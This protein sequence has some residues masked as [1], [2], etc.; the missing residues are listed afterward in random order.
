MQAIDLSYFAQLVNVVGSGAYGRDITTV[1]G[2]EPQLVW[3]TSVLV[4]VTTVLS[5]PVAQAADYWGRKWFLVILT[6]CGM[7]GSIIVS[8]A[9]SIGLAIFGFII[10]GLSFGAQPL[11]HAVVSE[12]LPRK[13]R[14]WAQ[15]S[16]NVSAAL[17]GVVGL[18]VGGA[19][20][21]HGNAAGFRAYWYMTAAIYAVSTV[22]CAILYNP[23]PRELQTSLSTRE[24]IG[25]LDWIGYIILVLGLTLFCLGLSW[26]QNP[27]SW[28]NAHVL[29]TFL[30][31]AG[32]MIV[33]VLYETFF[34]KDGM[35]H[36]DLFGNRNFPLALVCIFVEGLVFFA[37]NNYFAFEVSV[38]YTT[39][40]LRVGLHYTISFWLLGL[41]AIGAGLYCTSR[42]SVRWPIVWSF[43]CFLIFNILMANLN[44]DSP[45]S[46]IWG[47]PVFLGAGLGI[48]LI[49]LLTVA[50][51]S[52]PPEL[53]AITSGLMIAVRSLGATIGLAIYNAVFN[54]G[55]A[56]NL[57]PK[58]AAAALPLGLP[59]KS[60]G[61]LIEAI[62]SENHAAIARVPGITKEI[63]AAA[64]MALTET[65]VVAFKWVWVA[66]ACFSAVAII[67][68][69]DTF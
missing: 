35:V 3:L 9:N 13:H 7:I 17:G 8:R 23:P 25:R 66:A 29:A 19:L 60:L 58:I 47:Y 52:T 50:Q 64:I 5:P 27:Y 2:G 48:C 1:V 59:E 14:P 43:I 21:R 54:H 61:P 16:V 42:K 26:S 46:L 22:A 68:T 65:Y 49:A 28:T 44:I 32:F 30:V 63:V 31:G 36:H 18:L 53:I 57:A 39:D 33:F 37:A 24:K 34:K 62:I 51:F 12:V 20:T 41:S 6:F 15:T 69:S 10:S 55:F 4:I 38:L 40:P 11:L 45:E 67:R 56:A